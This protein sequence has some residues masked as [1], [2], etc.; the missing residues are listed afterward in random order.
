MINTLAGLLDFDHS[1]LLPKITCPA[2]VIGGK[3]DQV[4]PVEIQEE[5]AGLLPNSRLMLYEG[6]GHGNDQENPQYEN[7]VHKFIKDVD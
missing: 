3:E 6:Y 5:M 1:N 4:I 2:L 7:E